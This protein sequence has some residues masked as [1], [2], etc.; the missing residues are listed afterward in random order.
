MSCATWDTY[1]NNEPMVG[2]W[3]APV[4]TAVVGL[5]G[6]AAAV[7][8]GNSERRHRARQALIDERRRAYITVFAAA[9]RFVGVIRHV[10]F[11]R[12]RQKSDDDVDQVL[13]R[14]SDMR[15]E[16]NTAMYELALSCPPAVM[17]VA[18]ELRKALGERA[19]RAGRGEGED[20]TVRELRGRLLD[21]M[22]NVGHLP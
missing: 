7:W 20:F 22:R 19:D 4:C 11:V 12:G 2:Q 10:W 14:L 17:T 21:V 1:R 15:Q 8:V 16:F 9:D 13:A 18:E 3:I 5:A 6:I